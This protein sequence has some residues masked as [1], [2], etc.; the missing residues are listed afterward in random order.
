MTAS[1]SALPAASPIA[2]THPDETLPVPMGASW[3]MDAKAAK[4]RQEDDEIRSYLVQL[5][6]L[7]QECEQRGEFRKA[8]ACLDRMR[9]VNLR[10]VKK[11][12]IEAR[13]VNVGWK[14]Q[15]LEEQRLELLTFH[16]MWENKLRD[17][18][19]KARQ[20]RRELERQHVMEMQSQDELIRLELMER[21]P[22]P[23]KALVGLRDDLKKYVQ[24]RMYMEAERAQKAIAHREAQELQEFEVEIEKKLQDRLRALS[25]RLRL[26]QAAVEKRLATNREEL[27]LQRRSDFEKLAKKHSAALHAQEQANALVVARAQ[28][29]IRRQAK[30]YI[31]DPVKTGLELVHLT[32]TAMVGGNMD[33]SAEGRQGTSFKA[34]NRRS[35][36][37]GVSLRRATPLK[38]TTTFSRPPWQ[39]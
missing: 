37:R 30:A 9:E 27:L 38:G 24:Q 22:R 11:I 13:K 14:R 31:Q 35:A 3:P 23:S 18:D 5:D 8:Q 29:C 6:A 34:C 2:P 17:Y 15:M 33:W 25:E 19:E 28:D 7:R 1:S 4:R 39:D 32:E 16:D 21:R 26:G 10:Y 12:E 20:L 36:S